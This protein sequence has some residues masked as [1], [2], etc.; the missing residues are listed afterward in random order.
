MLLLNRFSSVLAQGTDWSARCQQNEVA[1]IQGLE[2]LF[3]NVLQI[4]TAGA[5]II[6]FCMF[7]LGGFQYMSSQGDAKG[8]ANANTTL[9]NSAIGLIGMIGSYLI[10]KLISD[11]TGIPELLRFQVPGGL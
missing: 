2:C 6:F 10:L 4:I 3:A 8:L 9:F 1:T 7:I 5:G 11:L